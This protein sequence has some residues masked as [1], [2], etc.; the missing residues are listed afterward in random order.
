MENNISE[1]EETPAK[2]K[3]S[4]LGSF[5]E[6]IIKTMEEKEMGK[7][8]LFEVRVEVEGKAFNRYYSRAEF[9]GEALKE[10]EGII[11]GDC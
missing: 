6:G 4:L 2:R 10:I 8:Y 3:E 9:G 7:K 5:H 11:G 1:Y